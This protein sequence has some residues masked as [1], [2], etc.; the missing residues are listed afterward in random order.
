MK[1]LLMPGDASRRQ[2][3]MIRTA[4]PCQTSGLQQFATVNLCGFSL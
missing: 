1:N 3:L 4:G 2:H